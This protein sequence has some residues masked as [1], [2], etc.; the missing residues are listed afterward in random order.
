MVGFKIG[1]TEIIIRFSFLLFNGLVFLFRDSGIILS[2]YAVC[3]IHELGHI[4]AIIF[5]DGEIKSVELSGYGIRIETSPVFS[6][7]GGLAVLLSGPLA[8]I[9]TFFLLCKSDIFNFLSVLSLW[10][11]IYNLLPFSFLDGGCA[12]RLIISGSENEQKY[13]AL[14]KAACAAAAV[15]LIIF[16][17][18]AE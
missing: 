6:V 2:F 5:S 9:I 10:E 4:T 18:N 14:R 16:V 13:E 15:A 11:G 1:R 3:L 17:L 8:N 12:V 7:F